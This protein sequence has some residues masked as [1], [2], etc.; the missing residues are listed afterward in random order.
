MENTKLFYVSYDLA[1]Y[2]N[3]E[4]QSLVKKIR[5]LN[6]VHVQESLWCLKV[7]DTYTSNSICD[8]LAPFIKRG[9]DKII[10]IETTSATYIGY[11]EKP[12]NTIQTNIIEE[13]HD[14]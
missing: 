9:N 4:Y 8:K 11:I 10:V 6:G 1:D 14:N 5:E 13:Y 7:K 3:N 2:D 12:Q